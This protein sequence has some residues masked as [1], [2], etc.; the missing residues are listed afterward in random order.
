MRLASSRHAF[1]ASI[2]EPSSTHNQGDIGDPHNG[3]AGHH[4][5][6][7]R[8]RPGRDR[9][10]S[11]DRASRSAWRC[12]RYLRE[13]PRLAAASATPPAPRAGK[14]PGT[15]ILSC[16][17]PPGP[18]SEAV[19]GIDERFQLGARLKR[20]GCKRH[21]ILPQ[22][23]RTEILRHAASRYRGAG[24]ATRSDALLIALRALAAASADEVHSSPSCSG[25]IVTTSPWHR[26]RRG[27]GVD[28]VLGAHHPV[29]GAEF[30]W[31]P[32]PAMPQNSV[33]VAPGSTA[34]TRSAL[35]GQLVLQRLGGALSTT[36]W[37]PA[38]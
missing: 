35:V 30:S 25:G 11:P 18:E 23:G 37:W 34:C 27:R 31:L 33:A 28:H 7:D 3:A 24:R 19:F 20:S 10:R 36:P 9:S 12:D 21:F 2:G 15:W 13:A 8:E 32:T 22:R 29:A 26:A 5:G 17:S 16:G 4:I 1:S 6:L 14:A 38:P